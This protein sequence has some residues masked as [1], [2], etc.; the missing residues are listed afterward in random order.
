MELRGIGFGV[1]LCLILQHLF[2]LGTLVASRRYDVPAYSAL[3]RGAAA[4]GL[5]IALNALQGLVPAFV[6]FVLGNALMVAGTAW[7][8]V[9]FSRL[10]GRPRSESLVFLAAGLMA[11]M[12]FAGGVLADSLALRY[13]GLMALLLIACAA[14]LRE[15]WGLRARS[16]LAL[17]MSLV[18]LA[19]VLV[20]A[21]RLLLFWC[22][23]IPARGTLDPHPL[24]AATYLG[25]LL[26]FAVLIMMLTVMVAQDLVRRLAQLAQTDPLTGACNRQGLRE[27]VDR[28]GLRRSRPMYVML[29]DLDGFKGINDRLGHEAGDRV[30]QRFAEHARAR[31]GREDVLVRLGGD[32]FLILTA[33]DPAALAATLRAEMA[34]DVPGDPPLEVSFGWVVLDGDR[35]E[36]LRRAMAAADEGLYR[37]KRRTR[38]TAG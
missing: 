28:G 34:A 38:P 9:G 20:L 4:G 29:A 26:L 17:P 22:L 11:A 1:S 10:C 32:E 8:W 24:N 19:L 36:D 35:S 37:D 33:G 3:R 6:P 21:T 14:M 7:F 2:L 23:G 13:T 5:G 16:L 31:L 18:L 30:L 25:V 15:A 27:L 12:G